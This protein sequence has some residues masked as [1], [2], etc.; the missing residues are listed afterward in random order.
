[1]C[2]SVPLSL[3]H[4]LAR[5]HDS[6]SAGKW[7]TGF[8][9][10]HHL[11]FE[12]GFNGSTIGS[13]Q[14]GGAYS[15]PHHTMRWENDHP[16]WN[17]AQFTNMPGADANR[18]GLACN[19]TGGGPDEDDGGVTAAAGPACNSSMLENMEMQCGTRITY[20]PA[21]SA[22]ACCAVCTD[23]PG[24]TCVATTNPKSLFSGDQTAPAAGP[25][26]SICSSAFYFWRFSL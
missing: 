26:P 5:R 19:Q 21:A 14:T 4:P 9:S 11:G 10:M 15:G 17:D 16:I 6:C 22:A 12:H 20:A 1:V 13:F 8:K 23:T 24:C 25:R 3:S 7:H 2:L 18:G